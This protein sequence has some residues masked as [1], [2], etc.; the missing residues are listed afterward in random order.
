MA[1]K[2][3]ILSIVLIILM[4]L[5]IV[6]LGSLF[7]WHRSC[8]RK[9]VTEQEVRRHHRG[10]FL[11]KEL[12]LSD[13]QSKM[14][15]QLALRHRDTIRFWADRMREKRAQLTLEMMKPQPQDTVINHIADEIG[16]IYGTLRKLNVQHY[17]EM[18]SVCKGSEQIA[19]LDTLFKGI[20][21]CDDAMPGR[22]DHNKHQGCAAPCAKEPTGCSAPA[23]Q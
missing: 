8:D 15:D 4:A 21:C 10:E 22:R 18:K 5:N 1:S 14:M 17:R 6:A 19:K 2:K 3:N 9:P 12:N 16:D 11:K 23:R 20:F 13:E 7:F